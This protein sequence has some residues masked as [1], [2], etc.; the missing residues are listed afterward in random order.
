VKWRNWLLFT[1][2]HS[3]DETELT[4]QINAQLTDAVL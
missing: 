2:W 1:S 3:P 4:D